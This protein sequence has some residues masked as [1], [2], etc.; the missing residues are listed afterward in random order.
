V[1]DSQE[2]LSTKHL[3]YH[4]GREPIDKEF[5]SSQLCSHQT[6]P[7]SSN[8]TSVRVRVHRGTNMWKWLN[9]R[10]GCLKGIWEGTSFCNSVGMD[11]NTFGQPKLKSTHEGRYPIVPVDRE[12]DVLN[13]SC[14]L[15]RCFK[16]KQCGHS[17][18]LTHA[19]ITSTIICSSYYRKLLVPSLPKLK[20]SC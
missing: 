3:L 10:I 15:Q 7:I 6:Q 14:T 1:N 12:G 13:G 20:E 5:L 4:E 11:N 2:A 18:W 19:V 8:K 16:N 17:S 9:K